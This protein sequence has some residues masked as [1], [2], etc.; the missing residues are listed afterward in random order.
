MSDP[1]NTAPADD[2]EDL[3]DDQTVAPSQTNDVDEQSKAPSGDDPDADHEA[4][5]IG[6]IGDE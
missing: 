5:G 6:V 2:S 1:Q 3:G 4:T